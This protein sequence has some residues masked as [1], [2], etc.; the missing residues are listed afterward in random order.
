MKTP[1]WMK[2]QLGR[3]VV[4]SLFFGTLA[5]VLLTGGS[6]L[7]PSNDQWLM[8]GDAAQHQIGWEF[9]RSTALFQWPIGLNPSLG[10]V[11]SSSIVFTDS[12]PLA[13]FCLNLFQSF[14]DLRSNTSGYGFGC[15]SFSSITFPIESFQN[16]A[17]SS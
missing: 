13:S 1:D 14:W 8:I 17:P 5:F 12:I 2:R 10:L 11:F 15:V 3:R 6:I 9:F 4:A 16:S 7:L